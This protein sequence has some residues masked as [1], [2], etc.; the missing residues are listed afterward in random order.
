M[1]NSFIKKKKTEEEDWSDPIAK[2]LDPS[3]WIKYGGSC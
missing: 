3:E 1:V 2:C